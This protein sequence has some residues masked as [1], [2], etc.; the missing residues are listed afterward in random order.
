M[1]AA[2]AHL[3]LSDGKKSIKLEDWEAIQGVIDPSVKAL[4]E[5][6][7]EIIIPSISHTGLQEL[8]KLIPEIQK[9]DT[10]GLKEKLDAMY[11]SKKRAEFGALLQAANFL[12]VEPLIKAFRKWV[13]EFLVTMEDPSGMFNDENNKEFLKTILINQAACEMVSSKLADGL[14][15]EAACR[16]EIAIVRLLLEFGEEVDTHRYRYSALV[17]ASIEGNKEMAQMVINAGA[18]VNLVCPGFQ[19]VNAL[20]CAVGRQHRELV[21]LLLASG[22]KDTE[23]MNCLLVSLNNIAHQINLNLNHNINCFSHY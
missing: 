15:A 14:L 11:H 5:Q 21:T 18:N 23:T 12:M 8:I 1:N 9:G 2:V 20:Q 10:S 3:T 17:S 19:D 16:D 22:A 7:G 13:G 4:L 6:G